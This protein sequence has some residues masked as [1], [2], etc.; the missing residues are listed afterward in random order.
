MPTSNVRVLPTMPPRTVAERSLLDAYA[1]LAGKLPGTGW[2]AAVRDRAMRHFESVGLPSRRVEAYKYTDLRERLKSEFAPALPQE[3]TALQASSQASPAAIDRALGPLSAIDAVRLVLVDGGWRADLSNVA[4]LGSSVE[5][6]P[7]APLLAKAPAW[8]E[9]KF[10]EARLSEQTPLTS[11][12]AAFMTDG[13][14]LKIKPGERIEKPILIVNAT[15][16]AAGAAVSARHIIA[17]EQGAAATIIE[18]AVNLAGAAASGLYNGFAD[19]TLADDARLD[20]IMCATG[21]ATATHL[22]TT[23][24]KAAKDAAYRGFQLTAGPG[25]ARNEIFVELGG[26]GTKLDLSGAFLA[27]GTCHADTTL[28][29]DHKVPGCESRELFKGVLADRARGV[30]QGKI[31][32]RPGADQTDGKQMAR[33]L[34]LSEE[35][36]FDSKPELEIYAD[37]VACGHGATAAA[38]DDDLMFYCRS[39]GIPEAEARTLL[40]EAF[41]GDAIEKV[42]HEATRAALNDIARNWLM[43]ETNT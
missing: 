13:V 17:V 23:T 33:A 41:I 32:V 28:V 9:G 3:R 40:I 6:M 16:G 10:A 21:S 18:A 20:H 25:L 12:N 11:L 14:L 43:A 39:R 22:S 5:V 19:V 7:L 30:F 31:I 42:E 26:T 15:S 8:L 36:E 34:L 27:R 37:D 1:R 35:A 38:L 24:V 4:A 29:V 2:V